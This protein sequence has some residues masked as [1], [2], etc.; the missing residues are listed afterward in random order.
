METGGGTAGQPGATSAPQRETDVHT[1][2][3]ALYW[4][5]HLAAAALLIPVLVA[6]AYAVTAPSV[7]RATARLQL[8]G[9]NPRVLPFE[10]VIP[11]ASG[12]G[13]AAFEATLRDAL[14]S[15][16]LARAAIAR[17][18]VWDDPEFVDPAASFDP[19]GVARGYVN[20]GADF[21]RRA[22]QPLLPQSPLRPRRTSDA[23][24]EARR[25]SM[26]I[27]GF[28]E[29][30]QVGLIRNSRVVSVSFS[31]RDP[32]LAADVADT[33]ARIYIEQEVDVR[34]GSSRDASQWLQQRLAEQRRRLEAS[35]QALQR[36][37]EE[38]GAVAIEDRQNMIVGEL[39][40]LNELVAAATRVRTQQ[41]ARYRGLEAAQDNPD[42]LERF[43]DVLADN[44]IREQT[45]NL[46]RLRRERVQLVEDLGP[47][48][49]EMRRI[50]SSIR[51]AEE[52]LRSEMVAVV[53][54]A[55]LAYQVAR[56]QEQRLLAEFDRHTAEALALDRTGIEYGVMQRE[57]DSS[58]QVYESL[59]QRASE[60]SVVGELEASY[61]RILDEAE[62]PIRPASPRT[63]LVLL[64]GVMCGLFAAMGLVFGAELLD[65]TIKTPEDVSPHLGVPFLGMIPWTAPRG[66]RRWR[67]RRRSEGFDEGP[68]ML[69]PGAPAR[70]AESIRSVCTSL[71]FSLP[72]DGCRALLVTSP[73]PG[74]GKSWMAANLAISL[75]QMG[76]RTLLVDLDLRQPHLH[77]LFGQEPAPGLS[78]RL[79]AGAADTEI[80]RPTAV[81]G[82]S[83][84]VAGPAP[85]NALELIGSGAFTRFLASC[86]KRFDWI[87]VDTVPVLPV[88]DA[89]VAA[90]AVGAVLF[91]VGAGS[92]PRKV[93]ADALER[94]AQS[95]TNVVGCVLNKADVDRHPYY[96]SP[97]YRRTYERRY[98]RDPAVVPAD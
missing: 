11:S 6:L 74:E 95:N 49:P 30:L 36:F 2:L 81:P 92:T 82:L 31:A 47:L 21:L 55:R 77:D 5:R 89:L 42:A 58:R 98:H 16:S 84:A 39:A 15:R 86:R 50:E 66:G 38:H 68:P 25:E 45:Q 96:Y 4:R 80:V 46:A 19:L 53:E 12:V 57:A 35:E 52:R 83:L 93:A 8:E 20:R 90:R 70:F 75:A 37:R 41:E 9:R 78:N 40:G 51:D 32:Q 87:V 97:Y 64:T 27:N 61:I 85:P 44:S 73:A 56:S 69:S 29:R 54:S 34:T 59:L 24:P 1:Y 79:A 72:D 3:R 22:V 76:Q 67:W 13:S 10:E 94:L 65:D 43:P 63:S 14:R 48:H 62:V 91:V 7:Y 88:A 60:T 18:D 33:L 28:L 23:S 26:V 17:L 71:T